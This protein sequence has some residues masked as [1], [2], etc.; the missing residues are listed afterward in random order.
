MFYDFAGDPEYYSSHAAILENLA[1]S[2]KGDNIFIIVVD[3]REDCTSIK[4][5]VNYWTIFIRNQKFLEKNSFFIIAGSHLDIFK[6]AERNKKITAFMGICEPLNVSCFVLNCCK[7]QSRP[8]IKIK[9]QIVSITK[10]SPRYKLSLQAS[11]LLGLLEKD[12]SHVISC[13]IQTLLSHIEV[14]GIGLPRDAQSLFSILCELH[15]IGLLFMIAISERD[16]IQLVLNMSQLTNEVHRLLFSPNALQSISSDKNYN[17]SFNIGIIP[18]ELLF[19]KDSKSDRESVQVGILPEYITKECL[20]QLQYCQ[21]VSHEDIKTFLPVPLS[22]STNQSYLFFPALCT[23]S[24]KETT[25]WNDPPV[26]KYSQGWLAQCTKPDDY[27]PPRFLHV[28]L[29]R[30]VLKFTLSASTLS[31]TSAA[32]LDHSC[33]QRRCCRMWTNGVFWS[34]EEG[35][36]CLVELKN[37]NKSVVVLIKS[38][39]FT[40][41]N[42][43]KYFN[44]IVICVKDA[45]AEFCHLIEPEYYLLDSTNECDHFNPDNMY[46]MSD[47]DRFLSNPSGMEVIHSVSER[48]EMRVSRLHF[49][50]TTHDFA[51]YVSSLPPSMHPHLEDQLDSDNDVDRDLREIA[52]YMLNWD[53]KLSTHLELTAIDISD[54]KDEHIMKPELQR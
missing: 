44:E 17:P 27:F 42:F 8:V 16:E 40:P 21:E 22:D 43:I 45:K 49:L 2:K 46:R 53:L 48:K 41:D 1:S 35:V 26:V 13:P 38:N 3:L 54:I 23:A 34:M 20:I 30:L 39:N 15:D 7:P 9:E 14:T 37:H 5:I 32:S 11:M 12:F 36:K 24:K 18:Q 28:L 52:Y 25:L 10:G 33:F 50:T 6:G 19:C 31:Q 4:M 47:V 51:R 29:L